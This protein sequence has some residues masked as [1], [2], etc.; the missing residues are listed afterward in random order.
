MIRQKNLINNKINFKI[1]NNKK[2]F[3]NIQK[4]TIKV[5]KILSWIIQIK[6]FLKIIK[7]MNKIK[8]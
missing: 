8:I 7:S 6:I 4:K 1:N 2:I 5:L 3:Y